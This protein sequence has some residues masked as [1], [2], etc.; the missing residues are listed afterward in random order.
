MEQDIER[1]R[2]SLKNKMEEI[3]FPAVIYV[4]T[5]KGN[6]AP[7][8]VVKSPDEYTEYFWNRSRTH[9]TR[10]FTRV[11]DVFQMAPNSQSESTLFFL[12]DASPEDIER[13]LKQAE[14]NKKV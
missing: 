8:I 7:I 4:E 2:V 6:I 10:R 3:K 13:V 14:Q 11:L 12:N 1:S 5:P 9:K